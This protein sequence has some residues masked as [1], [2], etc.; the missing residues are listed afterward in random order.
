MSREAL[1]LRS[2]ATLAEARALFARSQAEVLP[3]V[4]RDPGG[5]MR[6][7]AGV[8]TRAD[9]VKHLLGPRRARGRTVAEIRRET[10]ALRPDDALGAAIGRVLASSLPALPVVDPAGTVVGM[11]SL[12]DVLARPLPVRV[13]ARQ[14]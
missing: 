11:L 10:A 4:D 14:G 13:F 9:L 7:F 5:W 12:G 6:R 3:V 2:D 8:V 1:T